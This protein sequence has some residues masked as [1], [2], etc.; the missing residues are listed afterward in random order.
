MPASTTTY[1]FNKPVVGG[2]DDTWGGFL[3]D[4]WDDIDDLLDGTTVIQ[5]PMIDDKLLI[6]DNIDNSKAVRFQVSGITPAETRAFIWPDY[7]GTVA[8]VAGTETLT[9]KTLT[10]PTVS[11]GTFTGDP[12]LSGN[13]VFSGDPD[14]SGVGNASAIRSDLGLAVGTDVQAQNTAL[15]EIADLTLSQGDIIFQGASGLTIRAIGTSGQLF[16]SDGTR[17]SWR[18]HKYVGVDQTWQDVSGSRTSGTSYQNTTG[19]PIQ[20]TLWTNISA[21]VSD[22]DSTWVSVGLATQVC[23]FVVP[24]GHYYRATTSSILLWSELR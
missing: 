10:S 24:D 22:D 9:N 6:V 17:G 4:N 19:R 13:P 12:T 18:D 15:Q 14:L 1:S 8:T 16:Q 2:D 23:S 7:N 21:E 5:S 11:A 3:N 20:V